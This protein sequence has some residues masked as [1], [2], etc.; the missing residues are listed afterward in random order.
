MI[1]G[2]VRETDLVLPKPKKEFLKR[3]F[4]YNGATIGI[5]CADSGYSSKRIIK[6]TAR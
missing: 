4:K 6:S 1:L 3:S 2:I 5:I